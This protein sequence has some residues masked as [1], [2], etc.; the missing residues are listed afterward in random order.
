MKTKKNLGKSSEHRQ[1]PRL[2]PPPPVRQV[3]QQQEFRR[4]LHLTPW[5]SLKVPLRSQDKWVMTRLRRAQTHSEFKTRTLPAGLHNPFDYHV[6][7]GQGVALY[8]QHCGAFILHDIHRARNGLIVCC[9]TS[10][11]LTYLESFTNSHGLLL[12]MNVGC[13]DLPA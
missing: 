2:S 4:T 3:L 13:S 6:Y 10:Y 7:V 9:C 12:S 1:Q 11:A 5:T 8:H